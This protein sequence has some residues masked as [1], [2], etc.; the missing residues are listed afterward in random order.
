[1]NSSELKLRDD[2]IPV[3]EGIMK[4]FRDGYKVIALNASTGVGKSPILMSV[5]KGMKEGAFTT[6]PLR[7]LVDQYRDTIMKFPDSE[8]GWV[9]VGRAGY[10]CLHLQQIENDAYSALS[11]LE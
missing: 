1:M 10:S 6:T 11:S 8:F 5:V 2:Q 4:N 9:I 3:V 7:T